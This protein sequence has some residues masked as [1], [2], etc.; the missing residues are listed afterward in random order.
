MRTDCL[1]EVVC[2]HGCECACECVVRAR[3]RRSER[4]GGALPGCCVRAGSQ[5]GP[6]HRTCTEFSPSCPL[7]VPMSSLLLSLSSSTQLIALTPTLVLQRFIPRTGN[8]LRMVAG[9][10]KPALEP[11][12][13][14][15]LVRE[16]VH[17]G[18][19]AQPS[20][21]LDGEREEVAVSRGKGKGKAKEQNGSNAEA[22]ATS[23]ADDVTARL[24]KLSVQNGAQGKGET[25]KALKKLLRS[26]NHTVTIPGPGGKE[27]KRVLT[28]WKMADYAYKREPCPFPTRARG[29][30]TEKVG[31]G[32]SEEY[33]IVARGYDK[34]FNVNE[35]SWTK[36]RPPF[37]PRN[38]LSLLTTPVRSGTRS[39]NTRRA[40]TS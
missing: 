38:T 4:A 7:S 30:F 20:H 15:K 36:V 9:Y 35:V 23:D 3:E 40:R 13:A 31:K 14:T 34:F 37:S 26:T 32:E 16:L 39:R 33:R 17:F 19:P 1:V 22:S 2:G 10:R 8:L 28:S 5:G 29:L 21:S 18:Q 25:S 12:P 6:F 27:E 11:S 24:D